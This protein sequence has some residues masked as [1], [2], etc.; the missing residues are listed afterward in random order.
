MRRPVTRRFDFAT[1]RAARAFV[2]ASHAATIALVVALPLAPL[3]SASLALLVVALGLRA[4]RSLEGALAGLVLRSDG[5][6]TALGRDGR[7]VEGRLAEGSV[8]APRYAAVAW[9]ANGERFKRVESVPWDRLGASAHRELRVMLR[10]ATSGD[11]AGAPAS[12]LRASI[13]AALSALAWP[14]RRWR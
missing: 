4:W 7:V 5:S 13:S 11:E 3:M 8:A 14:A 9:R 1:S 2:A 10:Y 6:L 12:H